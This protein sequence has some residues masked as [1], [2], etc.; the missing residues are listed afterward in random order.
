MTQADLFHP[1]DPNQEAYAAAL[2]AQCQADMDHLAE[3][4]RIPN[5][6]EIG[7]ALQ[8]DER[9]LLSL[10]AD[11]CGYIERGS[12]ITRHGEDSSG[13]F[14]VEHARIVDKLTVDAGF[15]ADG[16]ALAVVNR[17]LANKWITRDWDAVEGANRLNLTMRGKWYLDMAEN[18]DWFSA[19]EGFIS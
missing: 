8:K 6:I 13:L 1:P 11:H 2:Q 18:D 17:C 12:V 9:R 14:S 10:I 3:Q 19:A 4:G 16:N 15:S 5:W 7:D